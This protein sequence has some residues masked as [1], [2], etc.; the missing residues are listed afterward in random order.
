MQWAF[1][2]VE[3]AEK[4]CLTLA[5][6]VTQLSPTSMSSKDWQKINESE[7]DEMNLIVLLGH[8]RMAKNCQCDKE[9]ADI[10]VLK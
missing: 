9:L 7:R 3:G 5:S 1:K 6:K 4:T 2:M 10:R 8:N